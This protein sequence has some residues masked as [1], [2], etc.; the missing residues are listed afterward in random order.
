[1]DSNSSQGNNNSSQPEVGPPRIAIYLTVVFL[2]GGFLYFQFRDGAPERKVNVVDAG[3]KITGAEIASF[4]FRFVDS[5][6]LRSPE[7]LSEYGLAIGDKSR[8]QVESS[9]APEREY[10]SEPVANSLKEY[11]AGS[12]EFSHSRSLPSAIS[13]WR[14]LAMLGMWSL[15]PS[16]S[17]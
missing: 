10:R 8:G 2:L 1:M 11:K 17:S 16:Q 4:T 9:T 3:I 7:T 13:A 15:T 5:L 12:V 6:K 14:M